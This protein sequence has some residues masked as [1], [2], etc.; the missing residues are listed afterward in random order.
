M[1]VL[2]LKK[3]IRLEN[4]KDELMSNSMWTWNLAWF[5]DR[6]WSD[7]RSGS[8]HGRAYE[9]D[10][11]GYKLLKSSNFALS[12]ETMQWRD[13]FCKSRNLM[14]TFCIFFPKP[15]LP[16]NKMSLC[17]QFAKVLWAGL[18]NCWVLDRIPNACQGWFGDLW[19]LIAIV[20]F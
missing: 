14:G 5:N 19:Q 18:G 3:I 11:N 16:L 4:V 12:Y 1:N 2:C 17:C 7:G 15:Y 8:K 9:L 13:Y 20:S 10:W 6:K